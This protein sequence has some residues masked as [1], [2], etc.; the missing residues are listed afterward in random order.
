[1]CDEW[2]IASIPA[3]AAFCPAAK[4]VIST[5]RRASGSAFPA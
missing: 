2:L 1:M 3:I 4:A 5:L